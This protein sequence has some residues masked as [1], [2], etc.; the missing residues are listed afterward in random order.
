MNE[1]QSLRLLFMPPHSVSEW[2][3]RA[4]ISALVQSC[5]KT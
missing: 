1:P 3:A 2:F 5:N 4:P